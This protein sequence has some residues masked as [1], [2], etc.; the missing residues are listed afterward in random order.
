MKYLHA[1]VYKLEGSSFSTSTDFFS[2]RR[3]SVNFPLI[4]IP[5]MD[6]VAEGN[7]LFVASAIKSK[8]LVRFFIEYIKSRTFSKT[9]IK[10]KWQG[11]ATPEKTSPQENITKKLEE[12]SLIR[13]R[14]CATRLE[15]IILIIGD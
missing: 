4:A 3:S 12:R 2:K 7:L 11:E 10:R 15:D 9:D 8:F 13:V 1:N 6:V 14:R 5:I